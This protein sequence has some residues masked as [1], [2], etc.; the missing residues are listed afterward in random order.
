M[1]IR[2]PRGAKDSCDLDAA[3]QTLLPESKALELLK[4]VLLC[5]AIYDRVLQEVF[6]HG[7][8]VGCGFDGSATAC[9]ILWV[10]SVHHSVFEFPRVLALAVQQAGVVVT[11][12]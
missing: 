5:C 1:V 4:A 11:L 7:R 12:L 8:N 3:L 9:R 6:A 10:G 2:I